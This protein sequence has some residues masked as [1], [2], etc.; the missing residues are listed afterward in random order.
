MRWLIRTI[1]ALALFILLWTPAAACSPARFEVSVACPG[2]PPVTAFNDEDVLSRLSPACAAALGPAVR[3]LIADRQS[4]DKD[5]FNETHFSVATWT[6]AGEAQ[7]RAQERNLLACR[8]QRWQRA[9]DW[10]VSE[11]AARSYCG[12]PAHSGG[13]CPTNQL[14]WVRFPIFALVNPTAQIWPYSLAAWLIVLG[15]G[16]WLARLFRRR[17]LAA[18]LRP[19]LAL[20]LGFI[21]VLFIVL[22]RVATSWVDIAAWSV[23]IY[24]LAC[25]LRWETANA[26]AQRRK[27]R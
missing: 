7:L 21:I 14:S 27:A 1:F 15:V 22:L 9:G 13:A 5:F 19:G 17:Q 10:L 3:Q 11:D 24:L 20:G 8:Y 26:K 4:R 12:A 6:A 18:F 23:I 25:T 16:F 2:E